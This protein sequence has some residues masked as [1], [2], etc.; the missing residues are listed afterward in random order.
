MSEQALERLLRER[1]GVQL[2]AF[3]QRARKAETEVERL[4]QLGFDQSEAIVARARHVA[5]VARREADEY[6]RA[7]E[8]RPGASFGK[9]RLDA[10]RLLAQG[11]IPAALRE[12]GRGRPK[13]LETTL[14]NEAAVGLRHFFEDR[15]EGEVWWAWLGV[16]RMWHHL[17]PGREEPVIDNPLG[18][19]LEAERE[20]REQRRAEPEGSGTKKFAHICDALLARLDQTSSQNHLGQ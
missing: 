6:Q 15:E 5:T 1:I 12:R 17:N 19:L 16:L 8:D 14:R 10:W 18:W 13:E 7:A 4:I 9:N 2:V 20:F 11:R 3:E